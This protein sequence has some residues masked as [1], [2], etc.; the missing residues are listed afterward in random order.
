MRS[1]HEV[2]KMNALWWSHVCMPACPSA[3]L[4][5]NNCMVY[6]Y[7]YYWWSA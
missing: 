7:T 4:T 1:L 5:R 2:H 6:D 3:R